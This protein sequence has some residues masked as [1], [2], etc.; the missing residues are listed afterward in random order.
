MI[1]G[2]LPTITCVTVTKGRCDHLRRSIQCYLRQSYVNKNM[3][4]V[5]QGTDDDNAKIGEYIYSLNRSDI[6]YF[7]AATDLCLGAMRNTSVEIATGRVICQWDDDDLYHPDRLMLQYNVL[8][9]DTRRVACLYCDFLKYFKTTGDVYW[10]DWAGEP[11]LTHRFLP[12]SVM[13]YKEVF[14]QFRIFYPQEGIQCHVEE[15]L[16]VL[17]KLRSKG[18]LGPVWSGWHYTYV[19]HGSNVYDLDHHNLTLDTSWGKKVLDV[20]QLLERRELL[21]STFEKVGVDS[22]VNVRSKDG[23]AFTYTPR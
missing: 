16:N 6:S 19:F 5:S 22:P 9:A 12:G 14:G 3:V 1:G 4:I 2:G 21:E 8:R 15:D 10:C 18:D 13:F 20:E 17:E 23:V 7:T 11:L